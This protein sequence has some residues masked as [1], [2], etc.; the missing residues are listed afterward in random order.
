MAFETVPEPLLL[1]TSDPLFTRS[2][3]SPPAELPVPI[4]S[5]PPGSSEIVPE[6]PFESVPPTT[7]TPPE[8]P[9]P[10]IVR[11][12]TPATPTVSD[13]AL[14]KV[15]PV[16]VTEPPP[17]AVA[18]IVL[19]V[20]VVTM[21]PVMLIVPVPE[22]PTSSEALLAH[23]P[24]LMIAIPAPPALPRLPTPKLLTRPL[25]ISSVPVPTP[26]V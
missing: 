22:R 7:T 9:L 6:A 16:T 23:V 18:P 20:R 15:P 14:E 25:L 10:E 4:W 19:L 17:P 24:P 11:L 21:P 26:P 12:P 13:A 2:V 3:A 1:K 5:V 8:P